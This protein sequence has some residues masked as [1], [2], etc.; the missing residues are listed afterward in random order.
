MS[1]NHKLAI[2]SQTRERN[3]AQI[4]AEDNKH[5]HESTTFHSGAAAICTAVRLG[6]K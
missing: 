5:Q 2:F 6:Y 1:A 3:A 4:A